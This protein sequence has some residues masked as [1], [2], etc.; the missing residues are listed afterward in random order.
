[1]KLHELRRLHDDASAMLGALAQV[2]A[3]S[4]EIDAALIK[5]GRPAYWGAA[6]R[7]GIGNQQAKCQLLLD[8][9][10]AKAADVGDI[11]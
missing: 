3:Y 1:M 2:V 6:F 4:A 5:E 11:G 10:A 9:L 8:K 7:T